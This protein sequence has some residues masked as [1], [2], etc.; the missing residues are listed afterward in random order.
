MKYVG[1]R[2]VQQSRHTNRITWM[3]PWMQRHA[4]SLRAMALQSSIEGN[5]RKL[6]CPRFDLFLLC[7]PLAFS[8]PN[9]FFHN[10]DIRMV[11]DR[12]W[13]DRSGEAGVHNEIRTRR[14]RWAATYLDKQRREDQD[15]LCQIQL[16]PQ[17][18]LK[19]PSHSLLSGVVK[20]TK[21]IY[22]CNNNLVQNKK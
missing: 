21:R 8:L 10:I 5:L 17:P 18:H 14:P 19:R 13:G 2:A 6:K 16:E 7:V 12:L 11:R 3:T 20:H 9:S 4:P 15:N 22:C 1:Q